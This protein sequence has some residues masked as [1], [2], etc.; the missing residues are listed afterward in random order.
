[1]ERHS[2]FDYDAAL[3]LAA[4]ARTFNQRIQTR[5]IRC[6]FEHS[7]TITEEGV[8]HVSQDTDERDAAFEP[9]PAAEGEDT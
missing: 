6:K 4:W 3:T 5:L 7:Y 1:M 8:G 2:L 9:I